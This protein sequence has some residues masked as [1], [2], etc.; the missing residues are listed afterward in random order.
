[1][2]E[3]REMENKGRKIRLLLILLAVALGAIGRGEL[4]FAYAP[5]SN[6]T[7]TDTQQSSGT[8]SMPEPDDPLQRYNGTLYGCTIA[9]GYKKGREQYPHVHSLS[10]R[11]ICANSVRTAIFLAQF[12]CPATCSHGGYLVNGAGDSTTTCTEDTP[13]VECTMDIPTP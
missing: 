13:R 4:A 1:M 11:G 9:C 12:A 8:T 6:S 5:T 3:A 7:A 2:R 10:E